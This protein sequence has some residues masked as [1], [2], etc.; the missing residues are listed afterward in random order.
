[1]VGLVVHAQ[2]VGSVVRTAGGEGSVCT[3]SGVFGAH[4]DYQGD[5][6]HTVCSALH[7]VGR[8]SGVHTVGGVSGVQ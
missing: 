7:T 4:T 6:A 2:S 3:V 8:F 5:G 1:M